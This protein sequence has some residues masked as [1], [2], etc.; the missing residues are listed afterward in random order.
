MR[1]IFRALLIFRPLNLVMIGLFQISTFF[2]L[3]FKRQVEDLN[4]L[5]LYVM[6]ISLLLIT[7]GGYAINDYFDRK[8]DQENKPNRC[9]FQLWHPILYWL[10]YSLLNVGG[11]LIGYLVSPTIA[12]L[13]VLLAA[14][15][16]T[17]SALFQRL[18]LVGNVIVSL[19]T[20]FSIYEVYLVFPDTNFALT[21]FFTI[22][23]FLLTFTRELVKDVEDRQGDAIAGYHT[24]P[25]V[26]GNSRA[27]MLA[28]G[29]LVFTIVFFLMIHYQWISTLFS[30]T[31]LYV[32]YAY[33]IICVVLPMWLIM[34]RLGTA[35]YTRD[36]A[37][38][39]TGLKY[40]MAT[41]VASMLLF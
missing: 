18:V 37:R 38:L 26:F 36:Y 40:V 31:L 3:D 19:C 9:Y 16:F 32:Y 12:I 4:D 39:S 27:I 30:G 13:M 20:A 15:L 7:A 8:A 6:V 14:I 5:T 22:M 2:F 34:V 17:Y 1:G 41:G 28:Q 11:V 23:A 29:A 21:L 24:L 35:R 10:T 25:I 33:N